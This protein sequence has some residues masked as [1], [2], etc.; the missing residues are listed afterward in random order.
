MIKRSL[1]VLFVASIAAFSVHAAD[2]VIWQMDNLTAIGG[3][4]TIQVGTPSVIETPIGKAVQFNGSPDQLL[5]TSFPLDTATAFT[6]ELILHP[7]D[8]G[9]TTAL[10]EPRVM[11]IEDASDNTKRITM[12]LRIEGK[13]WG[14]DAYILNGSSESTLTGS[15]T[16]DI[17]QWFNFTITYSNSAFK[18]YVNGAVE[19][20]D[21]VEYGILPITSKVSLGC[22]QNKKNYFLGAINKVVFTKRLLSPVEFDKSYLGTAVTNKNIFS[23]ISP[24]S[25]RNTVN[26]LNRTVESHDPKRIL[27]SLTG[28]NIRLSTKSLN[29]ANSLYVNRNNYNQK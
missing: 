23:T 19:D 20:S 29:V 12:E 1:I 28:Q 2:V 4:Q 5:I 22:R 9:S 3:N 26:T 25:Q 8:V 21:K 14:I 27:F 15:K 6:I 16:H 17:D 18:A 13:K 11:H 24:T 10:N 7:I